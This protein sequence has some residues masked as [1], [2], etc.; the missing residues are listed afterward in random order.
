MK[1][2][3]YGGVQQVTGSNFIL[4]HNGIR[5]LVDCGLFQGSKFAETLNYQDFAYHPKDINFVLLTHSHADHTGRL[6]KL[7]K[8]GFRGKV[9]ATKP[10]IDL[11]VIALDD[12][13][14]LIKEE[15]HK[16]GHAPLFSSG[17]L[18]QVFIASQGIEYGNELDLGN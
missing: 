8:D 5:I 9:Y 2:S 18:H 6:P 13:L 10:T 14:D 15:A 17:D 12:N 3:F 1:L 4:E 16:D 7:Y 11:S